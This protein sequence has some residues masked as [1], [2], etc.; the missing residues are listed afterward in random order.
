ML[1]P[2]SAL[3]FI[4]YIL[5]ICFSF[6]SCKK[7]QL[8][9]QE[10]ITW[11]QN[12][13]DLKVATYPGYPPYQF[14]NSK[15]EMRG[16][17]IDYL[18]VIEKEID[19]KF[20]RQEYTDWPKV[21]EDAENNKV[22]LI[23]EVQKTEQ[24]AKYLHFF[25][26]LF[27]SQIVI[28]TRESDA[29]RASFSDIKYK[30][31]VIPKD[32]FI[33]DILIRN[34][35]E[36]NIFYE[37]NEKE[38]LEALSNGKYDAYLGSDSN[39]TYFIEEYDISGL[40]VT[41][42]APFKYRPALASVKSN[43]M[44]SNILNKAVDNISM[45]KREDVF[46]KWLQKKY[47]PIIYRP[48]FWFF[49]I[50]FSLTILLIKSNKTSCIKTNF[51]Q[52]IS[53]EIR[54][55]MNGILG[56][57]ELLK[58]QEISPSEQLEYIDTIIDSG[59]ELVHIVD[60][61]LE[62]SDLQSEEHSLN[63]DYV[64]INEVFENVIALFKPKVKEKGIQLIFK[65][66]KENF[67]YTD[68]LRLTKILKNVIG[69]AVKFTSEGEVVI[70]YTKQQAGLLEIQISDTGI[71]IEKSKQDVIFNEFLKL[72]EKNAKKVSGIG[73]GLAVAKSNAVIL[74]GGISFISEENK[75]S[76]FHIKLPCLNENGE[77]VEN[78]NNVVEEEKN[79]TYQILIAEDEEINFMLVNS[80][81]SRFETH[82]FLITR[83]EN[84]QEAV[85]FFKEN[86]HIDL[87][88]MDIR[89]PVMDGY[90]ATAIIKK[91]KPN[92]PVI[93][94]TAYSSDK[95]IHAAHEAG[96]DSV[97]CKPINLKEFKQ[98]IIHYIS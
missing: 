66:N 92:V 65:N 72:E 59:K 32:Y 26:A 40:V 11:L 10:E 67:I 56:F 78:E 52:N 31:V 55:P 68:K 50:I 90:E 36:I 30:N 27:D 33:D 21:L 69:N 22:D 5:F 89:M 95:D 37:K 7:K 15:G 4:I 86:D 12:N 97:I 94:H 80:V 93:A 34:Y 88:L 84:G 81:L 42:Q 13:Q 39:I 47:F 58:K 77:S 60:N 70:S 46:S 35:P 79:K 41:G 54:T 53:H 25:Q 76:T 96:C 20:K 3:N 57:S 6:T 73:L 16:I 18:N 45:R 19:Y 51:L 2:N 1:K 74:G 98:T 17:F 48:S 91:L 61:V 24:K 71:G 64:N 23:L 9:N 38:C 87:V 14:K 43:T 75:G 83:A 8:L 28:V 63:S 82:N 49:I 29:D 62:I 85:D 44:L